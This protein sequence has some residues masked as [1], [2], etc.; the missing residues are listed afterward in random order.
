[1]EMVHAC[2]AQRKIGLFT[3]EW[4]GRERET[5]RERQRGAGGGEG[6]IDEVVFHERPR[7][8]GPKLCTRVRIFA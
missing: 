1:M 2:T 7:T 4:G 8:T 5:E 6:R 3:R